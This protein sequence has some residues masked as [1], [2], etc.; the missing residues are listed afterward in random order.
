[1]NFPLNTFEKLETPFY[2]Y[3]IKLLKDTLDKIQECTA[4]RPAFRVHYAIKANNNK[5]IVSTVA[6]YGNLGAD[7]VSWGEIE[8]ATRQGIPAEKIVYSGV[9]KT[10]KEI[11]N[12]ISIKIGCFNVESFEELKNINRI[13][14]EMGVKAEI[15]LR[16]NPDIDAHTHP[17]ITTGTYEDQFGIPIV[18]IE[19][20]MGE[21]LKMTG[22]NLKGLHFHIGSQITEM[23]P[24]RQLVDVVN[25][26]IN[27]WESRGINFRWI[28]VGGGLGI[29]YEN[30][31]KNPIAD[32]ESYFST[33]EGIRLREG[34]ELHFELGRAI[35]AQC[36]SLISRV[37]Y[38]KPGVN[39]TFAIIDAGFNDLMRPALYEARHK[40][41]VL[42][43]KDGKKED[44]Y[45][46]VG[47]ICESTDCFT[48]AE[49]LPE[50]HRGDI[51]AFR[52]AGAY[53][54]SMAST[55]NMRPMI[56]TMIFNI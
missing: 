4:K 41:D 53:G 32:F 42:T 18:Q 16:I 21:A 17:N 44:K 30:P 49:L 55:Y 54:E 2:A 12:A 46:V 3:D 10:D 48:K 34:Q 56:N 25:D 11:R 26:T 27:Y 33:F 24:F 19:G 20:I 28:N 40:I 22:I 51:I 1:M 37:L 39:K 13:A 6:S 14:E 31:D 8:W 52:S 35:V 29:D 36:G 43:E 15:A 45:D 7:C 47:P 9:G 5:E 38:I 23:T 50:L